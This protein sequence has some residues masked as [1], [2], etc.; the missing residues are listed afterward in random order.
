MNPRSTRILLVEDNPGDALLLQAV[1]REKNGP[2]YVLKRVD[3]LR[4]C[5]DCLLAEAFDVVLLDLSLPDSSGLSTLRA[6]MEK[7]PHLPIVVLTGL[8]D[9]ETAIQSL[10]EGAQD[11]L[12]KDEL[13][14]ALIKRSISYAVERFEL[15][16]KAR[17]N[18]ER[19]FLTAQG[20]HDGLWDWNLVT[21]RIFLSSRWKAMLGYSEGEVGDRPAEWFGRIHPE[22]LTK[23]RRDLSNH[24]CGKTPHFS[25]EHRLR[26]KDGRYRWVLGRGMATRDGRGRPTRVA[27]SFTDI[28]RHKNMERQ[29]ALR[30]YYDPLT[31]LPN[32][33]H[34]RESLARCFNKFRRDPGER[35]GLLFLDLD[36]F[37]QVNDRWGHDAGDELLFE[38]GQRIRASVR[39]TDMVARMGG[40]EFTV[41]LEPLPNSAEAVE[42]AER[43]LAALKEPFR[44]K[45][46]EL[47]VTASIGIAYVENA[48]AGP[49]AL[50]RAAD[51][52]MY[53]AKVA[54]RGRHEIFREKWTG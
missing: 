9:Q 24:L 19:Y 43:I 11:F 18:E 12:L 8:G 30:A 14:G 33:S 50:L 16:R 27:G 4:A 25:D 6:V 46:M 31:G 37:K 38:F 3:R 13:T 22:D 34:F 17:E 28:T 32:R 52:A 21:G 51:A 7:A 2:A 23:V 36:G 35:F 10:H 39:P 44:V 54:G 1:L 48:G 47:A 53:Q 29:L 45:G 49:D 15:L 41:L 20:S 26:Q 40:D 5:L 42:V